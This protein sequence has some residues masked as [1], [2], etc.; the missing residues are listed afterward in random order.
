MKEINGKWNGKV[1]GKKGYY[2]IYV[3]D[4][5]VMLSDADAEEI[6]DAQKIEAEKNEFKEKALN[7]HRHRS[8][9]FDAK[10]SIQDVRDLL[11]DQDGND[12]E[13]F[14]AALTDEDIKNYIDSRWK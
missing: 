10:P 14:N 9:S 5:K 2:N 4:S 6:L 1:Y 11:I 7:C 8:S 3:N 12:E 13:S